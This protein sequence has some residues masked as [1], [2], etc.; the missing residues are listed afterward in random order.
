MRSLR[1]Q[2]FRQFETEDGSERIMLYRARAGGDRL[3]G[4]AR[5]LFLPKGTPFDPIKA[6]LIDKYGPPTDETSVGELIWQAH[7]DARL[8]RTS[9]RLSQP[10]KLISGEGPAFEQYTSVAI[11][12]SAGTVSATALPDW[13]QS[14][15]A[16]CSPQIYV[17][18]WQFRLTVVLSDFAA[19]A[20]EHGEDVKPPGPIEVDL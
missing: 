4:I 11:S 6:Q 12:S 9:I 18:Y 2:D 19:F 14:I 17:R 15:A 13:L 16:S 20:R 7:D 1:F 10:P 8:C 3:A 5:L